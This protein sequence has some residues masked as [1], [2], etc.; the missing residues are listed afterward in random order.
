MVSDF[1]TRFQPIVVLLILPSKSN[2][3]VLSDKDI[4]QHEIDDSFNI[5]WNILDA[6]TGPQSQYPFVLI[7]FLSRVQYNVHIPP[8]NMAQRALSAYTPLINMSMLSL[9]HHVPV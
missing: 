8:S 7:F 5:Q 2:T 9:T 6:A 3:F 4:Y 1:I